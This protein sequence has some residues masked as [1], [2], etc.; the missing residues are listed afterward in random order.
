MSY[1]SIHT[2]RGDERFELTVATKEQLSQIYQFR[3]KYFQLDT[4]QTNT[5]CDTDV[6]DEYSDHLIVIEKTKNHIVGTYRALRQDVAQNH[7][8]FYSE[9]EFILG[10]L[11]ETSYIELGRAC[12]HPDYRKKNI[13]SMLWTGIIHYADLHQAKYLGGCASVS[14]KDPEF[15]SQIFAYAKQANL[16]AEPHLFV[17]PRPKLAIS[18]FDPNYMCENIKQLKNSIPPLLKG[19]FAMQ[20][21]IASFP[22]HDR[23]F[24]VNDFFMLCEFE[25]L[26]NTPLYKRFKRLSSTREIE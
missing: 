25:K 4:G 21:K 23:I 18:T 13:I 22:A 11:K 5:A 14:A 3:K 24:A 16:L 15:A 1:F 12:V 2:Q 19:Y 8:G 6:F 9:T 26:T 7:H 10:Y 17:S 20:N